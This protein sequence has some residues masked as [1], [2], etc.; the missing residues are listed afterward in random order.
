MIVFIFL[1]L[2]YVLQRLILPKKF[3]L[4]AH[5]LDLRWKRLD[6]CEIDIYQVKKKTS[7]HS[8]KARH[9][10]NGIFRSPFH[11]CYTFSFFV[12]IT[13]LRVIHEKVTNYGMKQKISFVYI[14]A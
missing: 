12:P 10:Q 7:R 4:P 5:Q 3:L 14:G 6:H 2:L 13:L 1:L 8:L 9:S 11:I